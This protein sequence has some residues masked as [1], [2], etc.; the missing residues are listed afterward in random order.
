MKKIGQLEE[1]HYLKKR[2]IWEDLGISYNIILTNFRYNL[3]PISS[4]KEDLMENEVIVNHEEII[5]KIVTENWRL[6]KLF[7]KV[8]TKLDASEANRYLNQIRYFQKTIY[9]SLDEAGMKLVNLEGQFFDAGM[10]ATP[11]NIDEFETDDKLIVEQM[12]E[13]LIMKDGIIRKQAIINL[14]KVEQ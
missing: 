11:L 1:E 3:V 14:I 2:A 9:D 4:S 7:M 5:V 8:I 13:P 12:I 10:A 6:M